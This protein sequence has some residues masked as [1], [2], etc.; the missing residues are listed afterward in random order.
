MSEMARLLGLNDAIG[1][2]NVV[3]GELY[4]D[5]KTKTIRKASGWHDPDRGMKITPEDLRMFA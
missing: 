3:D 2:G 4:Y 1:R 5:P